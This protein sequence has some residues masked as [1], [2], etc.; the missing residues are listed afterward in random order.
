MKAAGDGTVEFVGAQNGYGN[1]VVL[2]HRNG[3][4][5]AYGHLNGFARGFRVNSS[6]SQGR[7]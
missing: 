4:Y 1:I 6:V 5:T 7:S 2:K 3:Y